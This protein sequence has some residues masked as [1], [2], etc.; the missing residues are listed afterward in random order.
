MR[1]PRHP[2][3]PTHHLT[4]E[5]RTSLI[6]MHL[7]ARNLSETNHTGRTSLSYPTHGKSPGEDTPAQP[8]PHKLA[9]TQIKA[10]LHPYT[11]GSS[12]HHAKFPTSWV[13]PYMV[14]MVGRGRNA[15]HICKSA[16]IAMAMRAPQSCK[17]LTL[18]YLVFAANEVMRVSSR[19][20]KGSA[21]PYRG[22]SSGLSPGE[23]SSCAATVARSATRY[24][25]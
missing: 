15:R 7:K 19:R 5:N 10:I 23:G 8:H 25:D 20:T 17:R 1:R 9:K 24:V 11:M 18:H 2:T 4:H 21:E 3:P 13:I 14:D 6:C 12:L 16:R 22:Q